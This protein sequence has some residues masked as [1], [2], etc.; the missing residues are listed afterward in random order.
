MQDAYMVMGT[1]QAPSISLATYRL[2]VKYDR[3]LHNGC[4]TGHKQNSEHY[5]SKQTSHD[6]PIYPMRVTLRT[7]ADCNTR[8]ITSIVHVHDYR[9]AVT[10]DPDPNP[11]PRHSDC[12]TPDNVPCKWAVSG[13]LK[14]SRAPNT[15]TGRDWA[16]ARG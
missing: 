11:D 6:R 7:Y 5:S 3:S 12:G 2:L 16:H 14:P 4:P 15:T 9:L 1:A 13:V 10:S 8:Y